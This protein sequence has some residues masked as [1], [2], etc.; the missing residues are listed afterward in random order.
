VWVAG[1]SLS[2]AVADYASPFQK[3]RG[4]WTTVRVRRSPDRRVLARALESL[5]RSTP[6]TFPVL[7][8]TP[9][10]TVSLLPIQAS[11]EQV[12]AES[13]RSPDSWHYLRRIKETHAKNPHFMPDQQFIDASPEFRLVR[14]FP[15]ATSIIMSLPRSDP[16]FRQPSSSA[17]RP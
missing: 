14:S 4:P 10:G 6:R 1:A 7:A 16:I 12:G 13:W 9:G 8:T 3:L 17:G 5:T 2:V 11:F 15:S